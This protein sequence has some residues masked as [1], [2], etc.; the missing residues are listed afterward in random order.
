MAL[1]NCPACQARVS[2]VA[3]ECPQ[4]GFDLVHGVA[5][6]ETL[7][8]LRQR[9]YRDRMYVLKMF[10]FTAMAIAMIGAIP[11]L[12]SYIQ[13][14]EASQPAELLSHWGVYLVGVGFV[15]YALVRVRMLSLKNAHRRGN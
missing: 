1:I 10:S 6:E 5:D 14:I 2:N 8:T 13:A 7:R 15:F 12:F 3:K 9:R 4:C 11:M